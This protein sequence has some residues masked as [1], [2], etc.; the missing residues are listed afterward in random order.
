MYSEYLRKQID[1]LVNLQAN[2]QSHEYCI[3]Q[4]IVL[5]DIIAKLDLVAFDAMQDEQE[6]MQAQD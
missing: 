3:V 5:D 6:L 2:L 4:D 1:R